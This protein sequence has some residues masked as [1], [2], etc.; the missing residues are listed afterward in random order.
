MQQ[1]DGHC[2]VSGDP[3]ARSSL[4][5]K[6]NRT[7]YSCWLMQ[8]N[9]LR[10][11]IT[12][13]ADRAL[14]DSLFRSKQKSTLQLIHRAVSV[15]KLPLVIFLH[16]KYPLTRCQYAVVGMCIKVVVDVKSL[17]DVIRC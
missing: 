8:V 2:Q 10:K 14:L 13:P 1:I 16:H 7:N 15:L 11:V 17:L 12:I 5:A 3:N 4:P 6:S 9:G